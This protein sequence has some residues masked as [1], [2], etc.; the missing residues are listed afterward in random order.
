M[1]ESLFCAW[2]FGS[3]KR[4]EQFSDTAA[5]PRHVPWMELLSGTSGVGQGSLSCR[6]GSSITDGQDPE[7][8]PEGGPRSNVQPSLEQRVSQAIPGN[9]EMQSPGPHATRKQPQG[10]GPPWRIGC[11]DLPSPAGLLHLACDENC[12]RAG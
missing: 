3:C 6:L 9:L 5:C 2:R 8:L 7:G 1:P 11:K 10:E 4:Q 12:W